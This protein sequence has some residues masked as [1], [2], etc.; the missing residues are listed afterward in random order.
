MWRRL[1]AWRPGKEDEWDFLKGEG[2]GVTY[3]GVDGVSVVVGEV[4]CAVCF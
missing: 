3:E 4:G 1:Y 2:M